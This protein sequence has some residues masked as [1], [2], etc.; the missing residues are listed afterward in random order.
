MKTVFAYKF[1]YPFTTTEQQYSLRS[2]TLTLTNREWAQIQKYI[3]KHCI[4]IK[5]YTSTSKV[6]DSCRNLSLMNLF[7]GSEQFVTQRAIHD[8]TLFHSLHTRETANFSYICLVREASRSPLLHDST[9]QLK[10]L[11]KPSTVCTQAPEG[12]EYSPWWEP[13]LHGCHGETDSRPQHPCASHTPKPPEISATS[14]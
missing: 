5:L 4:Y 12:E 1:P 2:C 6:L 11:Y 9:S 10:H 13:W 8:K 7:S 14:W 3:T